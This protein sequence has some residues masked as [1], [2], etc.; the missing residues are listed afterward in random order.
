VRMVVDTLSRNVALGVSRRA[1]RRA[2]EPHGPGERGYPTSVIRSRT[3]PD[4]SPYFPY[5]RGRHR[6]HVLAQIAPRFHQAGFVR[7]SCFNHEK[8]C[9]ADRRNN[10][11]VASPTKA[12]RRA[13]GRTSR[14]IERADAAPQTCRSAL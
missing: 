12:Q 8:W 5:R 4:P 7:A 11:T 2:E 6:R 14:M 3:V 10:G 13:P 9:W 1:A